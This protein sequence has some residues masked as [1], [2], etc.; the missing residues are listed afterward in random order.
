[1]ERTTAT[2]YAT[3][4][5]VQWEKIDRLGPTATRQI[6]VGKSVIWTYFTADLY[7]VFWAKKMREQIYDLH[8]VLP[9]EGSDWMMMVPFY[10][11]VWMWRNRQ[12][13][14]D[15]AREYNIPFHWN[16]KK[17]LTLSIIFGTAGAMACMQSCLNEIAR[18]LR[19][20]QM[21]M[22]VLRK[23]QAEQQALEQAQDA[24]SAGKQAAETDDLIPPPKADPDASQERP[25]RAS[26]PV[27]QPPKPR[28]VGDRA[29]NDA[30]ETLTRLEAEHERCEI[31]D[32]EYQT[33]KEE[34]LKLF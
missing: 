33:R 22:P 5:T 30:F 18:M 20:Q 10:G 28:P 31:S 25:A 27:P 16:E 13:I 1:M 6:P 17:I 14:A 7:A 21:M 29:R 2:G 4:R 8:G 11:T 12:V 34:I 19:A 26:R 3:S 24:A 23:Q 32:T 15:I 9:F